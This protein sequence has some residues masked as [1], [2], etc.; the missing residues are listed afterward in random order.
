MNI[1]P[2]II[3]SYEPDGRL[4]ELLEKLDMENIG[5]V[6]IVDDG[7]GESYR[8]KFEQADEIVRR[9]G[10]HVLSHDI[11]R[12]K[13][14]ALKT[15]FC[16]VSEYLPQAVA[17]VTADSDGQHTPECISKVIEAARRNRESLIL[18]IRK[19][20]KEGIPWK[21][22]VGNRVTERIFSYMSG[23]HIT[24]TQTGLRGIP[25]SFMEKT[26]ELKGERFE[27]EMRMLIE[28]AENIDI[29]EVPI[30]TIYD[31]QNNH[32]THFRPFAD[33]MKV[34]WMLGEKFLKYCFSAVTSFLLDLL[35]F[36]LLSITLKKY[37]PVMYIAAAAV[38]AR[39]VSA[40]YNYTVNYKIVFESREK[41]SRSVLKYIALAL[42]QVCCSA[43]LTTALVFIFP[44]ISELMI[45]AAV[46]TM[47]FFFS[48]VIQQKFVFY[49]RR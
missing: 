37:Y 10:G 4:I 22:R 47:L 21:S 31:S 2:V 43:M 41:V 3:P 38:S 5:P 45:K 15:A 26:L 30:E 12:G 39:A 14:R 29:L 9:L 35:V 17:V 25:R 46:D 32:Q 6:F 33:S 1:I 16:Y 34:Y 44:E 24:D 23:V 36:F 13:G 40:A 49:S 19:F 8:G 28:A 20:D 42:I 27:F 7:S 18:G 11:N 48:Y